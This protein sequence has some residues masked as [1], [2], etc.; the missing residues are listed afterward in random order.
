VTCICR[1]IPVGLGEP[2][3]DKIEALLAH[4]MLSIPATKGYVDR[5][6]KILSFVD[7]KLDLASR[8]RNCT[9]VNTTIPIVSENLVNWEL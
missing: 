3:F 6:D 2:C 8:E 9:V 1:N 7:L 5:C 4:A